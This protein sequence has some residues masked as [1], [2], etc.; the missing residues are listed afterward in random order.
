MSE[1]LLD[2]V[3]GLVTDFSAYRDSIDQRFEAFNG[4]VS[5]M[6]SDIKL[7]ALSDRTDSR[8]TGSALA[9]PSLRQYHEAKAGRI[10]SDPDGGY[11]VADE[12]GPI[13][14][15]LRADAVVLQAGPRI[16]T[17]ASDFYRLPRVSASATAYAVAEAATVT[18]SSPSFG[19]TNLSAQAYAAR[20]L[21]SVEWFEDAS[22][23]PRAILADDLSKQ[24]ALKTDLDF[25]SG[26][27]TSTKPVIGFRYYSG[28]TQT[29]LGSGAGATPTLDNLQDALYRMRANNGRPSCWFMHPRTLNTFRKLKTGLSGD[30]TYLLRHEPTAGAPD[31]LFGLPV[32]TSSQI[33][34]AETVGG[35]TDCSYIVLADMS[36]VVVG[37][38]GGLRALFDEYSYASSRQV[39]VVMSMRVA[40]GLINVAGV[41]V[42]TGVRP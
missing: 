15:R 40:F 33:G 41:E 16:V 20:A 5:K 12:L 31:T 13:A 36:Q 24:L 38:R 32:Y 39:Q 37:V 35:S 17:M 30:L 3:R 9:L 28:V 42:L 23:D 22:G 27:G 1:I 29:E 4:L 2:E 11:L 8:A 34:I 25:L 18:E 19:T 10:G 6:Q 14:D 26:D 7:H 21:G